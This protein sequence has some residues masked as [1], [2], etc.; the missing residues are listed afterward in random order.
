M[1]SDRDAQGGHVGAGHCHILWLNLA[2]S[3]VCSAATYCV[4]QYS[5]ITDHHASR[6]ECHSVSVSC[7]HVAAFCI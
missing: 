5:S 2:R 7:Y 3:V 4:V 6:C 1:C